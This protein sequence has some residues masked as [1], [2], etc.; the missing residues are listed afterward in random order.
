MCITPAQLASACG[1]WGMGR[2]ATTPPASGLPDKIQGTQ[3]PSNSRCCVILQPQHVA[4]INWD[5]LAL[6]MYWLFTRNANLTGHPV[7]FHLLTV[8]TVQGLSSP[9]A[10]ASLPPRR[11]G[12]PWTNNLSI[13]SL[14]GLSCTND[15]HAAQPGTAAQTR[16]CARWASHG[17][18]RGLQGPPLVATHV[19][20]VANAPTLQLLGLLGTDHSAAPSPPKLPKAEGRHPPRRS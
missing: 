16:G 5:M 10:S 6:K 3:L 4:N 18:P 1:G 2:R 11:C 9:T 20:F 14:C 17:K 7:V 13:W 8:A 12:T 15:G 19:P